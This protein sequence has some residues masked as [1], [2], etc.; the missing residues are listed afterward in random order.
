MSEKK[1]NN[2]HKESETF[3]RIESLDDAEFEILG[4][5]VR[6]FDLTFKLIVLGN[7][8]VGKSC[9]TFKAIKK[10]FTEE[11]QV[12][13]GFEFF[14]FYIRINNKYIQLQIWDTCGM[15]LYRSLISSFYKDS[16]LALLVYSVS[17]QQSFED[18]SKWLTDVKT[19]SQPDIKTILIGNK[20]DLESERAVS[21][22]EGQKFQNENQLDLFV[23]TSAKSGNNV[24]RTFL[25][26]ARILYNNY[27]DVLSMSRRSSIDYSTLRSEN[28][29][30]PKPKTQNKKKGCCV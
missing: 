21:T 1:Q 12:T 22:E 11:H 16:A 23:E 6:E 24:E 4:E 29:K 10:Q 30:L 2:S 13:L 7:S 19:Q 26:A 14:S 15:E 8:G 9:L 27:I 5:E 3:Q 20:T 18:V 17:D 25:E 28:F